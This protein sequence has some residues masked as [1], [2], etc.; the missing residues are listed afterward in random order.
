MAN[1]DVTELKHVK[2]ESENRD[3][4]ED[5]KHVRDFP[6][7]ELT[8]ENLSYAPITSSAGSK[9]S[10][11][12]RVTVLNKISTTISPFK[13]TAW[14]GPSGSGKTSLISVAA[15]LT[16]QGDVQEGSLIS[17]NGEEGRVPKRLVGVV[18]QDDLLLSNLTVE[19][20]LYFAA[21]L[22]TP[23]DKSNAIVQRVVEATMSELGLTHIRDSVVGSALG[24]VRGIS[25]GERKRVAVG[26]ELVVRP[27]CLLLDEITSGLDSS[28]AQSLMS[29][30]KDLARL[31]HSI[32]VV[33]HQ[34][35]T[36]IYNMFDHLLLLSRGNVVYNGHPSNARAYLEV[37]CGELPPETGIADWMMD[38]VTEDEKRDGGSLMAKQW[39]ECS[40]RTDCPA[41]MSTEPSLATGNRSLERRMSS[42]RELR[43]GPSYNTRFLTQLKLL[44]YRTLK[45]QR[46][47]RLTMTAA[48]L[49]LVYLFFTALFWWRIPNNTS[50]VFE[51]NSLLFFM[52]IAQANG[53]VVAAVTVFQRERTLLSRERAKKMYSVSSYFLAKTVSD[54]TN[55]VLLPLLYSMIVYW[56]AGFRPSATAYMKFIFT[57]YWTFSTAQSMGLFLSV[58]IPNPQIALVLARHRLSFF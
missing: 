3:L 42:L 46:G 17:V 6:L 18:W 11:K 40:A 13:L 22:K 51:R 19:E 32:A 1:H 21:R 39:L 10:E 29:T 58:L 35:R 54:M 26:A 49:Q 50:H 9:G 16:R 31:G 52:L 34:P 55:N 5:S 4:R 2:G 8:M 53:I 33:I 45:Q 14:M 38:I 12:K 57:F 28:T 7:V 20:N 30:L 25:G 41:T 44:T 43:S 24:S 15:D 47:E 36:A 48:M 23:E 27:S 37:C 56:T